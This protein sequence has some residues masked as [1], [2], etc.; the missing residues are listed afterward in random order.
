[1]LAAHA[2]GREPI[3]VYT[4][5]G[6][7]RR[8]SVIVVA[9]LVDLHH[10]TASQVVPLLE[11]RLKVKANALLLGHDERS[12]AVVCEVENV[13]EGVGLFGRSGKPFDSMGCEDCDYPCSEV[14]EYSLILYGVQT[15]LGLG[16]RIA[17]CSAD[18]S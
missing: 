12:G 16:H 1:M 18:R 11:F 8:I 2:N 15:E 14:K 9:D 10:V 17:S 6:Q 4:W 7:A 3:R 5:C 13:Q